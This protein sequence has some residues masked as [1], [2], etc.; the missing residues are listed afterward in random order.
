[1][2]ATA[3]AA[4]D[5]AAVAAV[6][7]AAVA[8]AAATLPQPQQ[9][10][11]ALQAHWHRKS[12]CSIFSCSADQWHWLLCNGDLLLQDSQGLLN[13]P[14]QQQRTFDLLNLSL[15]VFSTAIA[16][17]L[18]AS[19]LA[20]TLACCGCC[21]CQRLCHAQICPDAWLQR[22]SNDRDT[23]VQTLQRPP[24]SVAGC[25][26]ASTLGAQALSGLSFITQVGLVLLVAHAL[27]ALPLSCILGRLDRLMRKP[28]LRPAVSG[29]AFDLACR[30]DWQDSAQHLRDHVLAWQLPI[31]AK[32]TAS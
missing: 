11:V 32:N 7:A 25:D 28:R 9:Q 20:P 5:A 4:I 6:G 30:H 21:L 15:A 10:S 23:A 27:R 3:A 13:G 22:L 17:A 29:Y 1:M 8:A 19:P 12:Y 26:A 14:Q 2:M 31:R 16:V 24:A 18:A